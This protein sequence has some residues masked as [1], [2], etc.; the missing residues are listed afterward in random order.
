MT[1]CLAKKAS[2]IPERLIFLKP[3]TMR[4]MGIVI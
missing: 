2:M 1:A 4:V 3:K